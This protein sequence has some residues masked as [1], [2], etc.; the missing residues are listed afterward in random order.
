MGSLCFS[1]VNVLLP[2]RQL[3]MSH[4]PHQGDQAFNVH[5]R[6]PLVRR[7]RNKTTDL[8]KIGILSVALLCS[9]LIQQS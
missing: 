6:D 3:I 7:V 8:T 2:T 5:H 9:E 1:Y 4:G